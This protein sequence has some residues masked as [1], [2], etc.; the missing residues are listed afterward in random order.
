MDRNSRLLDGDEV[1]EPGAFY[2]APPR[3][4]DRSKQIITALFVAFIVIV[5]LGAI[6][7]VIATVI[8]QYTR[9]RPVLTSNEYDYIIVGA[10]AAG[11]V[12]AARLTENPN[13]RVLLLEAGGPSQISTGGTDYA[14]YVT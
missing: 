10:G 7:T 5:V 4:A 12:L 14:R 3:K 11:C 6:G 13:V 8:V 2:Q 1:T 9:N